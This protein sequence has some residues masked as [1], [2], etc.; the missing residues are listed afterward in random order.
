MFVPRP[1][2]SYPELYMG[3]IPL[4]V[5]YHACESPIF[6]FEMIQELQRHGYTMSAG[7]M[8]PLLHGMERKGLLRSHERRDGSRTRRFY[9]ATPVGRKALA[10]AKLRL[11]ELFAELFESA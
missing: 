11:R 3:L 9:S 8:Y 7:T 4:H 1:R 5:L 10:D 2:R 6:G